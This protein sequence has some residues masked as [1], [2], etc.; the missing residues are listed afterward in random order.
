[1]QKRKH[2]SFTLVALIIGQQCCSAQTGDLNGPLGYQAIGNIP[3]ATSKMSCIG[4]KLI[5]KLFNKASCCYKNKLNPNIWEAKMCP[6]TEARKEPVPSN[7]R[8]ALN[9]SCPKCKKEE[10]PVFCENECLKWNIATALQ[11]VNTIAKSVYHCENS[12]MPQSLHFM[13]SELN[14]T[15]NELF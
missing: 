2:L 5:Y 13:K 8:Q 14:C 4:T 7:C 15:D 3:E 12:C 10:L 6:E 9:E 11:N 1:M